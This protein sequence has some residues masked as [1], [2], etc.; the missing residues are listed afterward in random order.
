MAYAV[1]RPYLL[2]LE[3]LVSATAATL[4]AVKAGALAMEARLPP[5]IGRAM[6][7]GRELACRPALA[8]AQAA[9]ELRRRRDA[10]IEAAVHT[11]RRHI[12]LRPEAAHRPA[13]GAL[14]AGFNAAPGENAQAEGAGS[15]AAPGESAQ[16]EGAGSDAAPGKSVSGMDAGSSVGEIQLGVQRAK[17]GTSVELPLLLA[18]DWQL[19]ERL[20]L[21]AAVRI[22]AARRL[23]LVACACES[24]AAT[25]AFVAR[26][27]DSFEGW[28]LRVADLGRPYERLLLHVLRV[29]EIARMRAHALA[30]LI[31][32]RPVMLCA[33]LSAHA[34][35]TGRLAVH[36]AWRSVRSGV[37]HRLRALRRVMQSLGR[38]GAAAAAC[39]L[40]VI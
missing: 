40:I 12:S 11:L 24:A 37:L 35:S 31:L 1:E 22:L 6:R 4:G 21:P 20:R 14:G 25:G 5:V 38:L 19:L 15:E 39:M 28:R 2:V 8:L 27:L 7:D 29:A 34:L 16:V 30:Y 32:L 26:K 17:D 36:D 10:C 13:A 18:A 9:A 23:E 3:L 33:H